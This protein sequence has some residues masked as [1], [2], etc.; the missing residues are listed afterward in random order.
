MNLSTSSFN[1]KGIKNMDTSITTDE[2]A[3]SAQTL[4]H[5]EDRQVFIKITLAIVLGMMVAMGLVRLFLDAN[6]ANKQGILG[7]VLQAQAAVPKIIAEPN[8]L[9]MFYGSSMTRAGFSPRKFDRD[10][11]KMGKDISSF[12]FGF[13]GLNPYYQDLLSRR[14]AEQF[15]EKDRKLK[16]ALIEF[17]PFQTTSTRWNRAKFSLDSFITMLSN[18]AELWQI[19]Q[20]DLSRGIHLFNIKYIRNHVSAEM[21]T[22]YY[23]REIFPPERGQRFKDDKETIAARRSLGKE[24]GELFEKEYPDYDGSDWYY[25]WQGA[26]TI[27][28]ERSAETLAIFDDYYAA[29]QTDAQMKNDRLSRIRSADIEELH[30]E[31]F[32]VESF[33]GIVKNFQRFSDK[34]E[35]VMLPKNSRYIHYTPEA[36]MRLAQAIKQIE[37]ATGIKI[38]NHQDIKEVNADMYRDTTHLSRYR[39][40]IAYTDFLLSEY[41]KVL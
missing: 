12:N 4:A 8:D 5:A 33:I 32:L 35:V 31:P 14:I 24:L 2:Q 11:Q 9:V 39:G 22:S 19:L 20:E 27:P 23:S 37:Q 6:G 40:D 1:E 15:I 28:Q 29:T 30:F 21:V 34:V 25:P 38:N 16:L 17:N 7:R 3:S 13:G 26:G 18:D 41:A 36:K 10:L